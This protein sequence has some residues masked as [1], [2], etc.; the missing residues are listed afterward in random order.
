[1]AEWDSQV[2]HMWREA[3]LQ[4]HPGWLSATI[5]ATPTQLWDSSEVAEPVPANSQGTGCTFSI[6]FLMAMVSAIVF[7]ARDCLIE[8][9]ERAK[10]QVRECF[11]LERSAQSRC[12][13]VRGTRKQK[14]RKPPESGWREWPKRRG[15]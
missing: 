14:R 15:E 12:G 3:I 2:K 13:S 8:G 9:H 5:P 7:D 11:E 1:M 4:H 6:F 10:E